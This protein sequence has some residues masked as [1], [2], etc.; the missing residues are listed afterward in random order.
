MNKIFRNLYAKYYF[1][2][3]AK[4]GTKIPEC[5]SVSINEKEKTID[6]CVKSTENIDIK[7]KAMRYAGNGATIY[8][9]DL[10]KIDINPFK[11]TVSFK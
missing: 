6:I 3:Y 8:Q 9:F 4:I 11:G 5:L 1:Y 10:E 2:K 7:C